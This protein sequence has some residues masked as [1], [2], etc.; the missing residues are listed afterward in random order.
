MQCMNKFA[1]FVSFIPIL[2]SPETDTEKGK[3]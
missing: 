3:R 2:Y 1:L